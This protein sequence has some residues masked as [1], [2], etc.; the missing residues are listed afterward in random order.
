MVKR[1]AGFLLVLM[2][3]ACS[4]LPIE[5]LEPTPA[6]PNGVCETA[7]QLPTTLVLTPTDISTQTSTPEQAT[8]TPEVLESETPYVPTGM[9]ELTPT[10]TATPGPGPTSTRTPVVSDKYYVL[11][12]GTPRLI[13]NFTKPAAGCK[14]MGVA[15]QVFGSG[16][17]PMKNMVVVVTGE[18][19]GEIIDAVGLTGLD[20]AYGSGGYEIQLTSRTVT[21]T[22]KLFAQLFDLNGMELSIPYAF[23]TSDKCTENLVIINFVPNS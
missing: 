1:M 6:C 9:A 22:G 20:S 15:G 14:W 12:E 7:T 11:Q 5:I 23:D 16:G 8:H 4:W 2:L 17:V 19:D 21:S 3:S 10:A 18:L 13:E